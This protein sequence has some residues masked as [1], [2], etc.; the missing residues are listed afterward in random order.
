M[1]LTQLVC[2]QAILPSV[3]VR[4]VHLSV[5]MPGHLIGEGEEAA[6]QR[7]A[8]ALEALVREHDAVFLLLDTREARCGH[9]KLSICDEH[10]SARV[11]IT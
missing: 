11:L 10:R 3:N 6:V 4:G 5:P 8:A 2:L 1:L 9:A 7:D